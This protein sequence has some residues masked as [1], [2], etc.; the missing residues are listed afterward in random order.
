MRPKRRQPA[1]RVVLLRKLAT[2][3]M[4]EAG[5]GM[6]EPGNY[7][8]EPACSKSPFDVRM[9]PLSDKE[10]LELLG[11]QFAGLELADG[12]H[13]ATRKALTKLRD[14]AMLY[15]TAFERGRA[16][17]EASQA[18]LA[19]VTAQ[20]LS[21]EKIALERKLLKREKQLL[22]AREQADERARELEE[23]KREHKREVEE[24]KREHRREVEAL[25]SELAV[26]REQLSAQTRG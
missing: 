22:Q 5:E 20:A 3:Q 4:S 23:L 16:Q 2:D 19:D 14:E 11:P 25:K 6:K 26:A 13:E 7:S 17:A 1:L 9:D 24:L 15:Q 8:G 21:A 12:L 10:M 18:W